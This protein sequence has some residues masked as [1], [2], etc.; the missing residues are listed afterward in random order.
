[1]AALITALATALAGAPDIVL[2]SLDTTRADALSCYGAPPVPFRDASPDT[3]RTPVMDAIAAEGIRFARFYAHAPSTLSS[4]ASMLS[5]RDPHEHG[6]VRNGFALDPAVPLL[7][8]RLASAGYDTRAVIGAAALEEGQGLER[9]FAVYDDESPSLRGLMYQ[10]PADDVVRRALA[11]VEARDPSRPLFLFVHFFDAHSPYEPP[12]PYRTRFA[13]PGYD[14]PFTEPDAPLKPL[15]LA[16][17]E[18]A[19]YEGALA[20]V[21]GRYLGEVAWL[22]AQIGAL[23]AGLEARGVLADDALLVIVGD[24]GEVLSEDPIFAWTHGNDVSDGV[25]HVPMLMK[26]YGD[27]PIARH[28][29]VERQAPMDQLAPTLERL[30]GLEPTLGTDLWELVRPGPVLDAGRWP[31]SGQRAVFME[32]TRPRQLEATDRWNNLPLKRGVLAGGWR[33]E[34][35][36]A[37]DIPPHLAD[38]HPPGLLPALYAMLWSWDRAAPGHRTAEMP[39]H[40]RRALEALGYLTDD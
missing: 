4:H 9:G 16:L 19:A 12:E 2:V 28:R 38:G 22:D 23:V 3:P 34:S 33:L 17:Q 26:A 21:N 32:A 8:E 18:G 31:E 24:H 7:T 29:V 30:A 27:V 6:V 39:E 37:H 1:M 15:I 36:P 13:V 35:D 40:T 5:G 20:A 25:L 11:T 10:T 14:G